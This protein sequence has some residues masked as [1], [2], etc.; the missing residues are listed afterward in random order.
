MEYRK[1]LLIIP[2]ALLAL[3]IYIFLHE[4]GHMLVMLACGDK[5]LSFSILSASVAGA[6]GTF[7]PVTQSL[8]DIA[9][10]A[11]PLLISLVYLLFCF[12]S[13]TNSVFF[14]FFSAFLILIPMFSLLAWVMV[15]VAFLFGY[16]T[17]ADDVIHFLNHSSIHPILVMLLSLA[18]FGACIVLAWKKGVFRIWAELF[19][20]NKRECAE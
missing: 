3:P 11:L 2:A 6:G 4:F 7:T 5:I 14:H 9:G 16:R 19:N 8:L 1:R 13:G 12:R 15:P 10:M 18:A 20:N 17:G